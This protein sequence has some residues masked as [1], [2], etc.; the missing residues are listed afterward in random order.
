MKHTHLK[1]ELDQLKANNAFRHSQTFRTDGHLIVKGD[2]DKQLINFSSNDYLGLA[3]DENLQKE[4]FQQVGSNK[5]HWMSSSSSRPLTGT[6]QSHAELESTIATSFN[7]TKALIFNSG[8]H[9]NTGIL[10]AITDKEDLI[11]ADKLVH[12]SLIDGMKLGRAEFKRFNHN[13]LKHLHKLLDQH[14][15]NYRNTWIVTE[16]LFSMNGDYAPLPELIKLKNEFQCNLYLD[17]AHAVGCLGDK[18]LGIA[19]HLNL[20]KDVDLIIGT[21]G[22]ALAG[23]GGFVTGDQTLI[24]AI[25]NHSR[26][27]L[28]S[29]ALPPINIDWNIFIWTKLNDFFTQREQLQILTANFTKDLNDHNKAFLGSSYIVPILQPGNERVTST[30]KTLNEKGILAMAIRSP[31]VKPGSE[32]IRFSLTANMPKSAITQCIEALNDL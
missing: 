14:R 25:I 31:T 18:G 19:D 10:P 7:K 11:L 1:K 26:S 21:F 2:D 32:R 8:Y 22:K 24:D 27:W 16:S 5:S 12:A 4:F 20:I 3:S 13:D 17:E 30:A 23:C 6:S 15:H 29:T 28:Y 9:A